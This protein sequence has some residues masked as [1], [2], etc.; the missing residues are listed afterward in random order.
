MRVLTFFRV[1][2]SECRTVEKSDEV[3]STNDPDGF[4]VIHGDG[5]GED[6]WRCLIGH[7]LQELNDVEC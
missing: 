6:T 7:S 2:I 3:Q 1:N 5:S 4:R